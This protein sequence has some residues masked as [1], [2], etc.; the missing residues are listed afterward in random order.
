MLI[1]YLID[2]ELHERDQYNYNKCTKNVKAAAQRPK[3]TN[4]VYC[5]VWLLHIDRL[6]EQDLKC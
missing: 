4:A 6:K 1:F 3:L 5:D 2:V